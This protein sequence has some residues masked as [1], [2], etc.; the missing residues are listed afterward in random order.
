MGRSRLNAEGR[1]SLPRDVID[2][3][4]LKAGDEVAFVQLQPGCFELFARNRSILE[5]KGAFKAP[6]RVTIE[7]M[8]AE[9]AVTEKMADSR[10]DDR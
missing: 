8:T 3:L 6:R 9:A 1:V 2:G 4:S 5:L 10:T 7:E